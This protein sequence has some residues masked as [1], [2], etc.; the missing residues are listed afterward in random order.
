MFKQE[1]KVAVIKILYKN[2]VLIDLLKKR[3]K[4]IGDG[5]F[6]KL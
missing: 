3:G 5:D 1:V 6:F 2:G 4:I